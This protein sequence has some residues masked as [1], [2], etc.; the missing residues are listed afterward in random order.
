[1]L[2]EAKC[3]WWENVRDVIKKWPWPLTRNAISQPQSTRSGNKAGWLN[4]D[5]IRPDGFSRLAD[6]GGKGRVNMGA[7]SELLPDQPSAYSRSA[8]N[9]VS[10][11]YELPKSKGHYS[12]RF[13]ALLPAVP[14]A[15]APAA[16]A[17]GPGVSP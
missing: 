11:D 15:G 9:S 3:K 5:A 6:N 7:F 8:S 2:H 1:M 4:P 12:N 17:R 13:R 16:S 10:T 14:M